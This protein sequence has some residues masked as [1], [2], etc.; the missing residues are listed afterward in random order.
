MKDS[1]RKIV[2]QMLANLIFYSGFLSL[3]LYLRGKLSSR[4][5]FIILMYHQVLD[6]KHNRE[7]H[8][9]LGMVTLE[10]TF[11]EQ[12][13]YLREHSNVISLDQLVNCLRDKKRLPPRSVVITFDDG[14]RDNYLFAFP[15]LRKYDL[16][17]AVFLSTDYIG[18]SRIFWFHLVNLILQTQALTSQKMVDILNRFEQISPEKKRGIAESLAYP[19]VFINELKKIRPQIQEKIITEM[20]SASDVRMGKSDKRR[21]TLG[22][23]E[24]REMG[25]NRICFGSHAGS[26]R[27]LTHLGPDQIRKELT[28]SKK[29]IEEK[30]K[31]PVSFFAYPN[32]DY[33]PQIKEL[34]KETG[35]LCACAVEGTGKKEYEMDLFALPRIGIHEGMSIGIRGGFSKALFACHIAGLFGRRRREYGRSAGD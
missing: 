23:D 6:V 17:A 9:P 30:T 15:I 12:M 13:G 22:W 1:L 32:G 27:I 10:N 5:D 21:M 11:A 14:W 20:L 25:E 4:P 26:H 3:Y 18:T 31:R 19:D 8:L 33:T 7:N 16:P 24:I 2:K 28:E 34:V 29:I 35:Y